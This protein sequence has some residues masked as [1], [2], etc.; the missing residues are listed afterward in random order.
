[1]KRM[2]ELADGIIALPGGYGTYYETVEALTWAQIGLHTKPVGLLNIEGYFDP[3]V[4][5]VEHSIALGYIY[6][7]HRGLFIVAD[8]PI[9]LLQKLD[10]FTPPQNMN[11]WLDRT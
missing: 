9:D 1:Q 3:F 4:R 6:P 2:L 11:R 10:E 8:T 5:M 7:E